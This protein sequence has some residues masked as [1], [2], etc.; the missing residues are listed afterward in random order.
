MS[1][2]QITCAIVVIGLLG[3][4]VCGAQTTSVSAKV[5]DL[6][7]ADE[8][9]NTGISKLSLNEVTALNAAFF[10]VFGI[11]TSVSV[12]R[13]GIAPKAFNSD[14]LEFYDSL[15]QAVAYVAADQDLTVYLWTGE[16]VAYLNDD[17]LFG[18][19][20]KHM[21]WLKDGAIYD[22]DGYIVAAVAEWFK[23]VVTTPPAKSFKQFKPFKSFKEFKP[24]KPFFLLTWSELHGRV[25]FLRGID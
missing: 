4:T 19:N 7:S 17:S 14:D 23:E 5:T 25:F 18:F 8:V 9:K 3:A 1:V 6:F 21:G 10:R 12:T 16:P 15:G 11:L 24:F 22:H 20:G 2:S 13:N